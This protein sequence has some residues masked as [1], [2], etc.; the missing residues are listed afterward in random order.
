MKRGWRLC[1]SGTQVSLD[2]DE[3]TTRG[4]DVCEYVT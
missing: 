1:Y 2:Q 4:H 3:M